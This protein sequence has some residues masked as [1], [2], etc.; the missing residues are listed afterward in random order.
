[1][2]KRL[3]KKRALITG[4][5]RGLGKAVAQRFA[6]EGADLILLGRQTQDLEA[7]D[8][9]LKEKGENLSVTLV[10]LDVRKFG[11]LE[12]LARTLKARF[13]SLDI[14]IGNA[15]VLGELG[16]LTHPS[17]DLWQ[18]VMDVNLTANW[19]LLKSFE[20]LLQA[21]PSG[22]AFFVTSR[23]AKVDK[24]YWGPYAISKAALEKMVRVYAQETQ[25]TTLKV[26]LIDP[27]PLR[28]SM[29]AKAFPGIDPQS[30]PHPKDVTDIFVDLASADDLPSGELFLAQPD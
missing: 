18:E 28:T 17:F 29:L 19:Q 16:P 7:L 20:P 2:A 9:L 1:M 13:G 27:G 15:G 10:P 25:K 5:P 30:V 14:L 6:E 8:D 24:A 21:S 22:R 11:A 26:N 23:L 3:L 4:A 12:E